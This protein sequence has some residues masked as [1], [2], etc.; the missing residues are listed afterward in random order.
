MRPT[1]TPHVGTE[2]TPTH[3]HPLALR[4]PQRKL[5][6]R[7]EQPGA[8]AAVVLAD[9][10]PIHLNADHHRRPRVR[11]VDPV[12]EHQPLTRADERGLEPAQELARRIRP[13]ID[14]V[15]RT[16]TSR[17]PRFAAIHPLGREQLGDSTAPRTVD[18]RSRPCAPARWMRLSEIEPQ[19]LRDSFLLFS[20]SPSMNG[21]TLST[22]SGQVKNFFAGAEDR[23]VGAHREL[24]EAEVPQ[25]M[26]RGHVALQRAV[27][28]HRDE[29]TLGAEPAPLA[30]DV[31]HVL[32]VHRG[33]DHRLGGEAVRRVV[34]D[35]RGLKAG[36]CLSSLAVA[37]L[38]RSRA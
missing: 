6:Q 15:P 22:I 19:N 27:R 34:G 7:A 4:V 1:R 14:R 9:E 23:L 17:S 24:L 3:D 25:R 10:E 30:L 20:S 36:A 21:M 37:S 35:E 31:L 28:L 29:P 13:R 11:R 12:L 2:P 18:R 38:S 26:Q 8:D 32:G 33:E 5:H 16:G